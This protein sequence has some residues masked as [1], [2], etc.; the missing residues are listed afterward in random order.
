MDV[1]SMF[2]LTEKDR[3]ANCNRRTT[4]SSLWKCG[5]CLERVEDDGNAC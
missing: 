5:G 3:K 4:F 2:T 1:M